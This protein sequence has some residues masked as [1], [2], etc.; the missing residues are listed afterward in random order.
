[1][2]ILLLQTTSETHEHAAA[3]H[4]TTPILPQK[5]TQKRAPERV[6][7]TKQCSNWPNAMLMECSAIHPVLSKILYI[8]FP[9]LTSTSSSS[10][11]FI[12]ELPS[13][14]V[15]SIGGR[16]AYNTWT[17]WFD[18]SSFHPDRIVRALDHR[19]N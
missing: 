6:R 18:Q 11:I 10:T 19:F 12:T 15:A 8:D 4:H 13:L 1:M 3:N 17:C 9:S 7:E 2:S 5:N 16:F 14:S